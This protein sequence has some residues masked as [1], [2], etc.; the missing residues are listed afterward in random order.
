MG[1]LASIDTYTVTLR[2]YPLGEKSDFLYTEKIAI[3]LYGQIFYRKQV[4]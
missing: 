2:T 3:I 4:L 1:K